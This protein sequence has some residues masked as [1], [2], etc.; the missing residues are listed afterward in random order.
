MKSNYYFIEDLDV[1]G[2]KIPDGVLVR[3]YSIDFDK[4]LY[5]YKKNSYLSKEKLKEFLLDIQ[6]NTNKT[7][8]SDFMVSNS[9]INKIRNKRIPLNQI[10]KVIISKKS[11]FAHLLKGKS[12]NIDKL[13]KDLNKL[14]SKK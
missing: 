10:P 8:K 2:D 1:S 14:F 12:I 6:D 13:V 7:P 9:T 11:Y 3:Q 4:K 5:N